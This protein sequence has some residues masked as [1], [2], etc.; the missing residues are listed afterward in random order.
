[1]LTPLAVAA[2]IAAAPAILAAP[3]PSPQVSEPASFGPD[4][5]VSY[6]PQSTVGPDYPLAEELGDG[7]TSATYHGPYTG[8]PTTTGAVDG[9]TT[10]AASI[11]MLPPNPTATYYNTGGKPVNPFPAP[12]TP[13]GGLGTNGTQPRYMVESDFDYESI[14]L[15][16]Y[17]VRSP[18]ALAFRRCAEI[19]C[20]N[21]LSSTSSTMALPDS[22]KP[23]SSRP[24]SLPNRCRSSSLWPIKKPDIPPF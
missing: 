21:G 18:C 15:G 12:F 23:N 13:A 9:P 14:A 4:A 5:Q 20:R 16:L 11:P 19:Y 8:T 22:Q 6:Q 2:I 24:V 17:Q 10:L 7:Y 3:A 1:M